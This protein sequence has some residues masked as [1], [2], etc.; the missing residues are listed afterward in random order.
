MVLSNVTIEQIN[1]VKDIEF[2]Y[3]IKLIILG[4]LFIYSLGAFYLASKW[5]SEKYYSKIVKIY[6]L[7]IPFGILL[8]F[9]PL[10]TLF[11]LRQVSYETFYMLMVAF[12]GYAL[13]IGLIAG[14]L[15]IFELAMD[16]LG[17]KPKPQKIESRYKL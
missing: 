1:Y 4:L 8:F 3:N 14:K 5:E 12:Y 16:M 9:Y 2:E 17:I 10:L 6:L 7:K 13:V 15:G 11:L